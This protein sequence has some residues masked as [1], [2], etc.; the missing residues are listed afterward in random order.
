MRSHDLASALRASVPAFAVA[1]IGG[2]IFAA[3]GAPLPWTLGPI[4]F[5]SAFAIAGSRWLMSPAVMTI[6]RPTVGVMVG[7]TFTPAIVAG[8]VAWWLEILFVLGFSV[9][10]ALVGFVLFRFAFRFDRVTA[11]MAALPAGLAELTVIGGSLGGNLRTLVLIHAIRIV[12]VVFTVPMVLTFALGLDISG[13]RAAEAQVASSLVDWMVLVACG[14]GGAALSMVLHV[15]GGIMITSLFVSAVVHGAGL[16]EASLPFWAVALA[17]IFIG[18]VLGARFAK[19][20]F[21]EAGLAL[22]AA[23]VWAALL[24]GLTLGAAALAVRIFG[25]GAPVALLALA[26]GGIAEMAIVTYALG[27]DVA[28]I[29]TCQ[30]AR[31]I[32]LLTTSPFLASRIARL[33]DARPDGSSRHG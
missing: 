29:V 10:V 5:C 1:A 18:S 22:V 31:M 24:M 21:R 30:V 6:A 8:L 15:P 2:A 3:L 23:I 14:L 19:I 20:A 12:T 17:Q 27:I 33:G 11:F 25:L 4:A 16:T 26:P 28:F 9:T 7:S 13:G 32:F